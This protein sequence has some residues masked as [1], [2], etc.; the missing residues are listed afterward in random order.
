ALVAEV[1]EGMA[2]QRAGLLAGDIITAVAGRPVVSAQ[3]F[4]NA[5]GQVPVGEALEIE[6]LRDRT[7]RRA[8]L[9]VQEPAR[10][11]GEELG[12]RFAGAVFTELPARL[13]S[14]R[15]AGVLI[16]ELQR[17]SRLAYEGLRP[18]DIITGANRERIRNTADLKK[19]LAGQRGPLVLQI[20]RNGESYFAR[21]D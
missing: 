21:I 12:P 2:G 11:D 1:I 17:R 20:F 3:D 18:G 6:Y 5:E 16:A 8:T 9:L 4:L 15:V 14:G 10:I 19:A 7:P 13:R